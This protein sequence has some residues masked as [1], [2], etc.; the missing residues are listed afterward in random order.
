MA[1]FVLIHSPLVGALTWTLVIDEFRRREI[2]A[3]AP[4]LPDSRHI[5]PPFWEQHAGTVARA[6]E[7]MPSDQSLIL[8][9]H[10][11]A[12][13]LLP[14]VRQALGRAVAGYIFV[15]AGIPRNGMSRLELFESKEAVEQFRQAAVNGLL[16]TWTGEDLREHIPDDDLR[17]RFVDD[18]RPLPLAVYEEPLP[19]FEAWP[20]APCGYLLF[21]PIYND[22]AEQARK[23]GWAYAEIEARHF[24]MLVDPA[25]VADA[26]I[27]L[28]RQMGAL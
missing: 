7:A 16:P 25:G 27:G 2:T 9:G 13:M 19:V 17:R 23:D 1:A 14:A 22:P 11:G 26:L 20:D 3:V 10:S 12:G 5:N 21:S 28:S 8:V 24:H 6:A 4:A 18:L 15:D